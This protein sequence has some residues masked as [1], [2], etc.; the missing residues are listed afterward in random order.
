M[1]DIAWEVVGIVIASCIIPTC[2]LPDNASSVASMVIYRL[3]APKRLVREVSLLIVAIIRSTP[4]NTKR[5]ELQRARWSLGARVKT[6]MMTTARVSLRIYAVEE[7]ALSP[8]TAIPRHNV[9]QVGVG[10]QRR[11]AAER[12]QS[13]GDV[14]ARDYDGGERGLHLRLPGPERV[15]GGSTQ[16]RHN[17]TS[18]RQRLLRRGCQSI[19]DFAPL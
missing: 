19:R 4:R 11:L 10:G 14:P 2:A 1:G 17:S 13:T 16:V 12:H 15:E 5:K 18:G 7:V 8:F 6:R 3:P 9:V